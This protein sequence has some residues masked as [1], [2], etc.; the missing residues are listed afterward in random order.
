MPHQD[1]TRSTLLA[2][3]RDHEEHLAFLSSLSHGLRTPLHNIFGYAQL[4]EQG[5]RG[6]LTALQRSDIGRI[7]ENERRLLNLVDAVLDFVR[8]G[9]GKSPVEDAVARD[10]RPGAP[11]D[12]RL[13]R[14]RAVKR[15]PPSR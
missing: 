3:W 15:R 4:L 8:W 14:P 5:L 7:R 12:P 6:P 9:G 1:G 10:A 13:S 11:L 2:R